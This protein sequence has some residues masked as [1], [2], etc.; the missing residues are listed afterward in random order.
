MH[1]FKTFN[2]S[3]ICLF[4]VFVLYPFKRVDIIFVLVQ[5]S[6]SQNKNIPVILLFLAHIFSNKSFNY[7]QFVYF[8]R[9]LVSKSRY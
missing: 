2:F 9:S 4:V 5:N 6:K 1:Q 3:L 7:T 8:C